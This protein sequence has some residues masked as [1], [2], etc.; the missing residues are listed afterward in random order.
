[1]A[2]FNPFRPGSVISPGMF[3]GRFEEIQ[4]AEHALLQTRNGNPQHFVIE[5]ERGIGKSSLCLWLDYL[6]KGDFPYDKI[7]RLS[8]VVVSVELH[9]GMNYDDIVDVLLS[10]LKRQ[11]A[12]R[13]QLLESCKKAWEF[14]SRFQV[15]GVKYDRPAQ[16][17]TDHRRLD[18]LTD[19]LVNL[20]EESGGSIEG[21][22]VLIDEADRPASAANLGQL[23]K[24]L[25]ERLARRRCERVCIGLFGLPGL[26]GKLKDSHES[27]LRIFNILT[28]EPLEPPERI[29]VIEKGLEEAARKNQF[30]TTI[31]EEAKAMIANLSEGYPHFLQEFAHCAFAIDDD[32]N[33]SVDDVLDGTFKE[34]GALNQ[35]GKKYF[36][37]LYI[38]Q[39][40][41]E[42]YRRVLIAM[43]ESLDG[44]VSRQAILE[45]SKVKEK[46]VD[47]A[48]HALRERKIIFL[49]PR[50]RGEYRLPTKSFAVWIRA[51]EEQKAVEARAAIQA[52]PS[53]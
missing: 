52:A 26:L 23:C 1:M 47:N 11:I 44:W 8:F 3:V 40:G 24:L 51:R 50:V 37:D 29:A 49:N 32:N 9:E 2:K 12:N 31:S 6:A 13:Q 41:S 15:G 36:A 53:S 30:E 28:L 25:T 18:E 19:V 33:I 10:E 16:P 42:D 14:L 7:N 27:S 38:D 48:L 35:L 5:G 43:A 39:I 21:V 17:V 46:I 20:I 4:V 34:H 22:A 45:R